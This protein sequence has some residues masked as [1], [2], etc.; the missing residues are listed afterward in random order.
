MKKNIV[1]VGVSVLGTLAVVALTMIVLHSHF[2]TIGP[3]GYS[4]FHNARAGFG[5]FDGTYRLKGKLKLTDEQTA[6]IDEINDKY[7]KETRAARDK[8]RPVYEN[9]EDALQ[10]DK[11][12]LEK[13]RTLLKAQNEFKTEQTI[14]M[15]KRKTEIDAVLTKEQLAKIQHNRK[16]MFHGMMG[17]G[18][19]GTGMMRF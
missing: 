14:L 16:G 4:G 11:V 8:I 19:H 6:K 2:R 7:Y 1:V 13:M 18:V 10:A 3:M 9:L 17:I 5:M 12:D 15:I